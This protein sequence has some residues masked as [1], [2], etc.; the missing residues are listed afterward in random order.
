MIKIR[1]LNN[2]PAE[3]T[4]LQKIDSGIN[5]PQSANIKTSGNVCN[6]NPSNNYPSLK[7]SKLDDEQIKTLAK[8]FNLNTAPFKGRAGGQI[9]SIWNDNN[10]NVNILP[11]P[12][13]VEFFN[14][15]P[16]P[17][18]EKIN[19]NE[20][21]NKALE[22]LKKYTETDY[23][24]QKIEYLQNGSLDVYTKSNF[25]SARLVAVT[26]TIRGLNEN[27]YVLPEFKPLAEVKMFPDGQL[28]SLAFYFFENSADQKK[29]SI[30]KCPDE[31]L[32]N[33]SNAKILSINKDSEGVYD[34]LDPKN[35]SSIIIQN[36][37]LVYLVEPNNNDE[38]STVK[39][40][41]E[42]EGTIQTA[43]KFNNSS[44][45]IYLY[46]SNN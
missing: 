39:P 2:K 35:I 29:Y 13:K 28:S 20:I 44:A 4:N 34:N 26:M 22:Y 40:Y 7:F 21:K 33:I 15:I 9:V 5:I 16:Q 19:E 25:D 12:A 6:F 24:I 14:K 3:I 11:N 17:R 32:K 42:V 10:V 37:N 8:M 30:L 36:V 43:G 46:A 18:Q 23:V 1:Q 38:E 31:V 27:I 45:L 41:F